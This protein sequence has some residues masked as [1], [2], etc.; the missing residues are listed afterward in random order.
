MKQ[1]LFS[2]WMFQQFLTVFTL[3][4]FTSS[5]YWT[6]PEAVTGKEAVVTEDDASSVLCWNSVAVFICSW[7]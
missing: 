5:F 3:T 1:A 7:T 2:D 6:K 4:V